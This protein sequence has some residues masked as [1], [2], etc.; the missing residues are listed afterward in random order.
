MACEFSFYFRFTSCEIRAMVDE[1][2]NASDADADT[3]VT[4]IENESE[5]DSSEELETIIPT[6][7][8]KDGTEWREN[9][10]PTH[11]IA[12][13]NIIKSAQSTSIAATEPA[14]LF[15][16]I[17]SEEI[18]QEIISCTNRKIGHFNIANNSEIVFIT[19]AEL[20]ALIGIVITAGVHKSGHEHIDE[21]WAPAA[22]PLYKAA[23]SRNR[24]KEMLRFIR[25]D[26]YRTRADRKKTNKAAPIS[27]IWALLN[28]NLE[29]CFVPGDCVTVDEQLYPFRGRTSFTQYIPSKPAK[30]GI[31]VF[32]ICDSETSYPLKGII[33][34]GRPIAGE[35][36]KNVG[37]NMVLELAQKYKNSGRN[38]TM[39][40]FF[41]SLA[42]ARQ[43]KDWN[44]TLV[45][46]V[47]HNKAFLPGCLLKHKDRP[48]HSSEFAYS[49]EATI[50][51]FVPKKNKAVILLST[52]HYTGETACDNENKPE[53][54]LYYNRT[55]AG[56]DTMDQLLSTYSSQRKTKRWPLAFFYN[57]V[58]IACLA[59]YK[60]YVKIKPERQCRRSFLKQ[61]GEKLCLPS[62]IQRSSNPIIIGRETVGN[63]IRLFTEIAPPTK[64]VGKRDSTGRLKIVGTCKMCSKSRNTRKA[65]SACDKPICNE[66]SNAICLTCSIIN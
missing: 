13:F 21:L 55:K 58:D 22:L 35:R 5:Y 47:R 24:F 59:A 10:L 42:L 64:T 38:I 44:L 15:G 48:V 28:L 34:T 18:T 29:R 26:D 17:F 9:P 37:M 6:R 63:A 3:E 50:C 39:D 8:A 31:K 40:N 1:D 41:T 62:I 7:I 16:A 66:H 36:Q 32:W 57:I 51:S 30:Y 53:I 43:L 56:V 33:Y 11:K 52:M 27:H 2:S 46:T 20:Q 60:L 65:C 23:M 12:K 14:E 49:T 61:L 25:F 4:V 54:I 19:L 45:G